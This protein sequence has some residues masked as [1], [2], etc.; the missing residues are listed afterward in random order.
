MNLQTQNTVDVT[1]QNPAQEAAET[2]IP[3]TLGSDAEE[4]YEVLEH[5]GMY[6]EHEIANFP[7]LKEAK[8]FVDSNYT[9]DE[10]SELRVDI[11]CNHS[12]EY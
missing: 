11:T 9:K 5:A 3:T 6:N 12:T 2:S 7:T 1:I 8:E 10:I 4:K